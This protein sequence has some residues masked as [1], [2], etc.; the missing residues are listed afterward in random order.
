[1]ADWIDGN[2][3][4]LADGPVPELPVVGMDSIAALVVVAMEVVPPGLGWKAVVARPATPNLEP[5][6]EAH[7]NAWTTPHTH[8]GRWCFGKTPMQTFLDSA[9]LAREKQNPAKAA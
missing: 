2:G 4:Y 7:E 9:N 1:M 3:I 8:Q 5:R 6:M